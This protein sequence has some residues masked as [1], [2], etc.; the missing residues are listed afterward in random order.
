[1]TFGEYI[2]HYGLKNS[3]GSVLRYLSDVY[4]GLVQN[5]PM[6]DVDDEL[7]DVIHWLGT[8]VRSVDSSL[9]DE[10]ERLTNPDDVDREAASARGDE[11]DVPASIV[12]DPRALRTLVR[13]E[14]FRW[15][16]ALAFGR[17]PEAAVEDLDVDAALADYWA[18]HDV[19]GIDGD[20]RRA[21]RFDFDAATGR[22]EQ[23]LADPAGARGVATGR[24]VD[25]DA[26]RADDRL[27]LALTGIV[28]SDGSELQR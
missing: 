18:E 8:L 17:R 9:L 27:V 20:A 4:K 14:V 23:T 15:V 21:D 1:M 24:R 25:L 12:D 13:N 26:S 7:D 10:W 6:D 11:Q 19:I 5:V 3:E 28:R 16:E 2:R 22:V